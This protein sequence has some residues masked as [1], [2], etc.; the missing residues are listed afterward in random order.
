MEKNPEAK[1]PV[2]TSGSLINGYSDPNGSGMYQSR[3]K[4]QAKKEKLWDR[5]KVYT[6][7]ADR[8]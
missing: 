3:R 6:N 5:K 2:R 7:C 8:Y 1:H 4:S